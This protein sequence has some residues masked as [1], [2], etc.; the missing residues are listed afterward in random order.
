MHSPGEGPRL[1]H[2]CVDQEH[3]YYMLKFA[4]PLPLQHHRSFYR[5]SRVDLPKLFAQWPAP[6]TDGPAAAGEITSRELMAA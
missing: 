5:T 3:R 1:P 4:G 2:C 6:R